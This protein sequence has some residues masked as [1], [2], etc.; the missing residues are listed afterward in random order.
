MKLNKI[1]SSILLGL[2]SLSACQGFLDRKPQGEFNPGMVFESETYTLLAVNGIYNQ[3]NAYNLTSVPGLIGEILS[4][5]GNKGGRAGGNP[6]LNQ[7]DYFNIHPNIPLFNNF[8]AGLYKG[9]YNANLVLDNIHLTQT[10]EEMRNRMTAEARFLRAFYYYQLTFYFGGVPAMTSTTEEQ[11]KPRAS[12]EEILEL[13]KEDLDFA[14]DHLP[15]RSEYPAADMGRVTKGAAQ[16]LSARIALYRNDMATAKNMAMEVIHSGEYALWEDYSTLWR[17]EAQ[18]CQESIFEIQAAS[19]LEANVGNRW[20]QAQGLRSTRDLGWGMNCPSDALLDAYEEGDPRK[21]ATYIAIGDT[22]FDGHFVNE[23]QNANEPDSRGFNYKAYV[24]ID[25]F[26]NQESGP[27]NL[28]E[29]RYAEMLLIAAEA[30]QAEGNEGEAR[31]Y[32]N[33]VRARARGENQQILPDVTASGTELRHAIWNERR[34]ELAMERQRWFD[35][36]RCD[37]VEPGYAAKMLEKHGKTA[38]DYETHKLMPIPGNQIEISNG[39]LVQNPG[40]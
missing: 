11:V 37:L 33:M 14:M 23:P 9:I 32:L 8:W 4:D 26:T 16:A 22:T 36:I 21:E 29:I 2:M 15:S 34:V 12:Q 30:L 10:T 20:S 27:I 6:D 39:V 7:I 35:L 31:R 5:D 24:P 28:R 19:N 13:I 1:I 25:E 3:L 38:F 17:N 18:N 40:Y